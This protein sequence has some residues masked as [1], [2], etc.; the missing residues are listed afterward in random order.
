ML[1]ALTSARLQA[2]NASE[3]RN[4]RNVTGPG[5]IKTMAKNEGWV[6]KEEEIVVPPKGLQD[7]R[8]EVGS[9]LDEDFETEVQDITKRHEGL[10]RV[11]MGMKEAVVGALEVVERGVEGVETMSVWVGKLDKGSES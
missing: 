5:V 1:A 7:G 9:I 10:G 11:L 4:V 6:L 3:E 8:W 2:E